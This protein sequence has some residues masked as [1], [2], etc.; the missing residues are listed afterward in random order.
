MRN[1]CYFYDKCPGLDLRDA[2]F[3][4]I[5]FELDVKANKWKILPR[6][7]SYTTRELR[8]KVQFIREWLK[9]NGIYSAKRK[10]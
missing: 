6:P 3:G 1:V 4:F 2:F 10:I 7:N 9:K 5:R 8:K